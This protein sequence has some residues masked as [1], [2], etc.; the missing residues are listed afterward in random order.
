[1]EA[2]ELLNGLPEQI[3]YGHVEVGV[4]VHSGA[5]ISDHLGV[6]ESLS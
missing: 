3:E 5:V 1:M 6:A 4:G 2:L